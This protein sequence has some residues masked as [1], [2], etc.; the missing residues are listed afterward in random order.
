MTHRCERNGISSVALSPIVLWAGLVCVAW[1]AP[2][3]AADDAKFQWIDDAKQGTTELMF[4]EQPILRYMYAYDASTPERLHDTYKVYH[5]VYGPGTK[6]IITKGPGGLYTHHRGLYLGWNK[7]GHDGQSDDFWHCTKGAHLKHAKF[8]EL[9]GD[10]KQAKFAAEIHWNDAAGKPVIVET[11]RLTVTR[12]PDA[13]GQGFSTQID[14]Q[15]QLVSQRGE[16]TLD[17]DRQHAGLQFRADQPVAEANGARYIRPANFPD[18][19]EAIEVGDAG[20]PPAH[21]N[22]GWFAMTYEL[23]GDK[24]TVEYLEDPALP[25]PSLYSERPYGRF[26]AFFK[27]TLSADKPL[28]MRYRLIIRRGAVPTRDQIQADYD[29]FAAQLKEAK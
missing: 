13:D 11:R 1:G 23:K 4:G 10:D 25:K 19:P 17:G 5:H 20:N 7:T 16:I 22:L 3:A 24:Y 26:G 8:V 18:K 14:F 2:A 15:T 29:A 27:T 9:A 6:T 21:I 12:L 28:T